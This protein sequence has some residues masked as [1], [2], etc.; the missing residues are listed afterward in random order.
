VNW[1]ITLAIVAA[2]V[3]AGLVVLPLLR[4][5]EQPAPIAATLTALIIPAAAVLLYLNGSNHGW[6]TPS[7]PPAV[8]QGQGRAG[9]APEVATAI[10]GLEARL[11]ENPEDFAGWML[12][13][14]SL[15]QVQRP[16]DAEAA[17]QRALSLS[18]GEDADA[19]LGVAEA[20]ILANRESLAG[21]AGALLEEVLLVEPDNAKA[22]FYG[23]LAASA[24]GDQPLLEA[25]WLKLLSLDPPPPVRR[26]VSEQL[27]AMG[28]QLPEELTADDAAIEVQVAL[29]EDLR[30]QI[31]EGAV[32][33]LVAR[34]GDSPG[35]PLAAVRTQAGGFPRT[36]R[37][38]DANAMIP[39]RSLKDVA[40]VRLIARVSNGG[41]AL[42]QPGDVFG[43]GRWSEGDGS[44]T[45]VMNQVV[46]SP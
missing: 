30:E 40:E 32:L 43:E 25:R 37:L 8:A 12:L 29:A 20:Q 28:T 35:P 33:F 14:N 46:S 1:F 44:V 4:N 5:R 9:M 22:L 2:L 11:A 3:A 13:G 45:I 10:S 23:G 21:S 38:S 27:Q 18:G 39:G 6:Q 19:R 16:V 26:I 41:D 24:R 31:G 34:D 15:L 7:Q 17:F 42:A 36:L